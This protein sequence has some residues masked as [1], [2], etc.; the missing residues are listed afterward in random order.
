MW[1]IPAAEPLFHHRWHRAALIREFL[2]LR[3]VWLAA[4][5]VEQQTAGELELSSPQ[6]SRLNQ[7]IRAVT[8]V[9]KHLQRCHLPSN[10]Y[11]WMLQDVRSHFRN[12]HHLTIMTILLIPIDIS[13]DIQ[14][15][16]HFICT[17][18]LPSGWYVYLL[19]VTF[20]PCAMSYLPALLNKVR[21][22]SVQIITFSGAIGLQSN[23]ACLL[24]HLQLAHMS[25]SHSHTA[26]RS[27]VWCLSIRRGAV[28]CDASVSMSSCP[29]FLRTSVTS[30][31]EVSSDPSLTSSQRQEEKVCRFIIFPISVSVALL[32][33]NMF[34]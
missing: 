26:G 4:C 29:Q 19:D 23:S 34:V 5:L 2:P 22:M 1:S 3:S 14:Y 33:A 9:R 8:Q 17:H 11:F 7:V 6:Q 18:V 28:C 27:A 21:L 12:G 13:I 10:D 32:S 16:L 24:G 20:S 30:Q 15:I 25:T 31:R